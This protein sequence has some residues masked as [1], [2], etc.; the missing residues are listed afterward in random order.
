MAGLILYEEP[1]T[2]VSSCMCA[3]CHAIDVPVVNFIPENDPD[4]GV[5]VCQKCLERAI[6]IIEGY[7]EPDAE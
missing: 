4:I 2:S 5:N 1:L 3:I 6:A 7:E